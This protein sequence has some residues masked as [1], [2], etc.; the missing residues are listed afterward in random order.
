MARQ[1]IPL[2]GPPDEKLVADPIKVLIT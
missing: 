2:P 1:Y